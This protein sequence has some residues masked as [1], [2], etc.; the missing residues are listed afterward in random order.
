[1]SKSAEIIIEGKK[2]ELPVIEG[3]E[4]EKGIDVSKLRAESGYITL[5]YGFKNTGSTTSKI[6][7]LNGEEG[8][9]RYRGY[10]IE[11]LC[12]KSNFLEVAF[13]LIYGKLPTNEEYD[14]WLYDIKMHTM[15]HEDIKRILE[16]FPSNAHPM[17]VLS[18][19]IT[20]LTAFY[21]ESLD[22]N[23]SID[24]VK[25]SI[26][27]LLA[28]LPTMAAW[29]YKNEVG[30][31]VNYPDNTLDYVSNF[32]KMM[33]ALPAEQYEVDP[34]ISNALDT[35]LILHADHEQNCSTSTVRMVGSSHASLY[36]SIS[37]GVN[38][39]WG[40]LHGGANQAVIEMLDNIK[41]DGGD[42]EKYIKKAKDKNDPFRLMGF[43]HRVYKNFDPRAKIIKKHADEVLAKLGIHDPVLD[44]AKKLEETALQDEYFIERK[45]FPNVDFYSGII[46]RAMG[47]PTEMFT[48]MFAMGR[49]PGWIAQW[50]EM[51]ENNEPIGRPRQIYTGENVRDYVEMNK[52]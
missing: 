4:G 6:T 52:R 3:T 7:F 28:K 20:S 2:Y 9:L 13:L 8:I 50:L 34:V 15:V 48:V 19:L 1:M 22:P 33:F 23:R 47:I 29:A 21:P 42:V 11:D 16:G 46:Y 39:L 31:P 12:E 37:A 24:G 26:V 17:G 49:L 32:L 40:P 43:G 38:A 25:L 30:H 41:K 14:Q 45:L 36:T 27:R 51:R 5:D 10:T 18:S 35:L 44:I